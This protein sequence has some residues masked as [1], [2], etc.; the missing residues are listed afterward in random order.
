MVTPNCSV[1]FP[2][3]QDQVSLVLTQASSSKLLSGCSS[4]A[5]APCGICA[6]HQDV[7]VYQGMV[8]TTPQLSQQS[9]SSTLVLAA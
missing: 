1:M 2:I 4:T 5:N 6:I 3:L 7:H 9:T 8:L